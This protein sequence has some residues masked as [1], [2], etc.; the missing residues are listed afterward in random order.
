MSN[1]SLF[2]ANFL[3]ILL[4]L[5][6]S[7]FYTKTRWKNSLPI[8]SILFL[9]LF[10]SQRMKLYLYHSHILFNLFLSNFYLLLFIFF[11]FSKR[12]FFN[13]ADAINLGK[14]ANSSVW[15]YK[16][17]VL[18]FKWHWNLS[19]VYWLTSNLKKD[20]CENVR[21]KRKIVII[22]IKRILKIYFIDIFLKS[23]TKFL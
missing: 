18:D 1:S 19:H 23:L 7:F 17:R 6:F 20:D 3:C 5:F 9:S 13:I 10:S 14:C 11:L 16:N 21:W 8:F 12:P 15:K 2:P 4:F 22:E